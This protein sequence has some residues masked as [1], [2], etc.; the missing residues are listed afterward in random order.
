MIYL[1]TR[2]VIYITRREKGLVTVNAQRC[3]K[4]Q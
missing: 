4:K 3:G 1:T 2:L